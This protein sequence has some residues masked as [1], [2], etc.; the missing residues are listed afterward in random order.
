V[1]VEAK[2]GQSLGPT[3]RAPQLKTK[4]EMYE[5]TSARAHQQLRECTHARDSVH[6]RTRVFTC[7]HVRVH[8]GELK[9]GP[10]APCPLPWLPIVESVGRK[11]YACTVVDVMVVV[12][13]QK[14]CSGWPI[15]PR[16]I[17]CHAGDIPNVAHPINKSKAIYGS[18]RQQGRGDNA[19]ALVQQRVHGRGR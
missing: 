3:S 5:L 6:E 10:Y 15:A 13:A 11:K 19:E 12:A 14:P 7:M 4:A 17:Q 8:Q 16:R 1:E 2:V 18:V 9:D